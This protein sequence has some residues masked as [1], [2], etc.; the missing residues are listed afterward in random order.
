MPNWSDVKNKIANFKSYVNGLST[1][2]KA[3]A[4]YSF[5]ITKDDIIDML[6]QAGGVQQLD[7]LR[8]YLASDT[9]ENQ[10]VP[11]IY[12]VAEKMDT[13]DVYNDYNIGT[14]AP[15]GANQPL[16]AATRPCP[17]YCPTL[18]YINS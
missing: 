17:L 6:A 13:N 8:V 12:V 16:L 14:T 3:Q 15:S 1:N 7:G 9:I 4:K 18:N 5:L 11:T 2:A 10:M